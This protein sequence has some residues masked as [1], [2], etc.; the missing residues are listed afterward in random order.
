MCCQGTFI[1]TLLSINCSF[2]IDMVIYEYMQNVW[3]RSY[4]ENYSNK[5]WAL[6]VWNKLYQMFISTPLGQ[7]NNRFCSLVYNAL[8]WQFHG[9]HSCSGVVIQG[10]CQIFIWYFLKAAW[11]TVMEWSELLMETRN[12]QE[13]WI[14]PGLLLS[15]LHKLGIT[16]FM[17]LT[18]CCG[19]VI[20]R[21]F[22]NELQQRSVYNSM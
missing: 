18:S 12:I 4:C 11:K 8:E 3:K 10:P 22:F 20:R 14:I 17:G 5:F 15:L 19:A 1:I 7:S 13:H 21:L 6:F 16:I 2:I 9:F